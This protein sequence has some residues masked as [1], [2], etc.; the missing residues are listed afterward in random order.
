MNMGWRI[1]CL[2]IESK[3]KNFVSEHGKLDM[4]KGGAKKKGWS[5]GDTARELNISKGKVSED[6]R[7]ARG[8]KNF[9]QIKNIT[10]RQ[11]AI[12]FL[13]AKGEF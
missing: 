1:K 13:K 2:E 10:E 9:P 4:S 7:L 6:L 8:I 12:I 11:D 5:I 3:H